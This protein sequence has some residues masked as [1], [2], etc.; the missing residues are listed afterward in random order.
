MVIQTRSARRVTD[1]EAAHI[2]KQLYDL[3]G[4]ATSLSGEYDDNFRLDA[5]T[6]DRYVLKIMRPGC[7]RAFIDLQI[8]ALHRLAGLPVARVAG[9]VK[10]TSDGRLVWLLSWLPQAARGD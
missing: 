4:T 10:Q 7:E 2:A 1:S 6:G 8:E 3:D 5:A 9:S